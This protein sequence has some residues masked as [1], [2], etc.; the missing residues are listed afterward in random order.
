MTR[1]GPENAPKTDNPETG[2]AK[3]GALEAPDGPKPGIH[4]GQDNPVD[5]L[6]NIAQAI[7]QLSEAD[8]QRLIEL[9]AGGNKANTMPGSG[10]ERG[11][12]GVGSEI[13]KG[14]VDHSTGTGRFL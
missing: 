1:T 3:S 4:P 12:D 13:D 9:L 7:G 11:Q 2:G 5:P 14:G 6:G 8:R 10:P